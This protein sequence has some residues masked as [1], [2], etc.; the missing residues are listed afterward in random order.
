MILLTRC[1]INFKLGKQI[2]VINIKY[3]FNLIKNNIDDALFYRSKVL[4]SKVYII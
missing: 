3:N 4:T 1:V 2:C